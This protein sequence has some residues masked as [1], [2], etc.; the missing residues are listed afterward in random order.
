[1]QSSNFIVHHSIF[2]LVFYFLLKLYARFA[3]LI[4][5]RKIVVNK[6]LFLDVDGPLLIAANHPN[7]F[8]DGIILTTIFKNGVYSLARGDVFKNKRINNFLRSIYL[9][10]V[11][12]TSEGVENLGHNYTTF[13]ACQQVFQQNGIVII[14]SEGRCVNEWHLRPLK[15]GT[16][17]L[18]ISTWQ[19][20]LP[21]KV[22]PVGFNYSGFRNFG[23]VVHINVGEQMDTKT[24][25]EQPSEGRQLLMFNA[26]LEEQLK[27]LVYEIDKS[28]PKSV[29]QVFYPKKEVFKKVVLTLPALAG[30]L[31]HVPFYLTI[32]TIADKKFDNDHHDSV[33]TSLLTLGYPFYLTL[34][35]AL[36]GL[37]GGGIVALCCFILL[38]F[39]AWAYVQ[40]K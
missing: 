18:A 34:L 22:V 5:C 29:K 25:L 13:A 8:L 7:S 23:K 9:L 3:V 40:V 31:V 16:A 36:A 15:K 11:Y 12:R 28:D 17:R 10:P 6:P 2:S 4:Y 39:T 30:W 37:I 27:G 14:F 32:K 35:A 1:M 21:L 33:V 19:K 38:P 24:I 20:S 26:Q